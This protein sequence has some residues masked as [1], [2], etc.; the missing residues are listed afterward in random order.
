[1][2][3][4]LETHI[5]PKTYVTQMLLWSSC[6]PWSPGPLSSEP[7][8][9]TSVAAMRAMACMPEVVKRGREGDTLILP[10]KGA[11]ILH[12]G[13]AR[14]VAKVAVLCHVPGEA[15]RGR[16]HCV[17]SHGNTQ[18]RGCCYVVSLAPGKC[19]K[20]GGR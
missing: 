10:L 5:I 20:E 3:K 9:S 18:R 17:A 16:Q 8:P 11:L 19:K 2:G 13:D 6:T 15:Q 7:M 1:M 12:Q 4:E 14:A